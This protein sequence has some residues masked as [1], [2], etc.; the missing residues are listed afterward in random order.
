[1]WQ[2]FVH[3]VVPT[4]PIEF[5]TF[6]LTLATLALAYVAYVGL[7]AISLTKAD[8][9]TRSQREARQCAI[10]R[11]EEMAQHIIIRNAE[12]HG[13]FAEK[14]VPRFVNSAG[15]VRFD[16]DNKQDLARALA[17]VAALPDGVPDVPPQRK[18]RHE[19]AHGNA[20]S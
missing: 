6:A 18:R 15:E 14:K 16:P 11:C 12:I 9:L 2:Q 5:W 10:A 4:D 8:M 20:S 7:K 13:A 1:M 19:R 3:L 17:W